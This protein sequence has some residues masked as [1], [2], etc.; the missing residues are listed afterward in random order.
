[1]TIPSTMILEVENINISYGAAQVLESVSLRVNEREI[2]TVIGAN[3]AGKTTLL[4]TIVGILHPISGEIFFCGQRITKLGPENLVRQG[5]VLVPER[6]QLF[7]PL[8]VIDNLMLGAYHRYMK[9]SKEEIQ[10][11]LSSTFELFP[12]LKERRKQVS[13]TLSGGE[14]Q[15]LAI[16]RGLLSKPKLIL[17]DEP[18]LGLAPL[19]IMDVLRVLKELQTKELSVLLVEQNAKSPLSISDRGYVMSTGKIVIEGSCTQLLRD[20]RVKVAYLGK[21]FRPMADDV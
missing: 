16:A 13:A 18:L 11:N 4:N 21:K 2:V 6:R 15:M 19:V 20:D 3:G 10:L 8:T 9:E 7:G 1:M 17:L 14:Q 5:L 12:I